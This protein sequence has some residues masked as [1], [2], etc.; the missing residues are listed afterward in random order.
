MRTQDLQN[1]DQQAWIAALALEHAEKQQEKTTLCL[2]SLLSTSFSSQDFVKARYPHYI[3][4]KQTINK[5]KH[6]LH[7]ILDIPWQLVTSIFD[8]PVTSDMLLH[9]YSSYLLSLLQVRIL[10]M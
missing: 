10:V 1:L 4:N 3:Q 7:C 5:Y 6:I 9:P 8:F 2:T